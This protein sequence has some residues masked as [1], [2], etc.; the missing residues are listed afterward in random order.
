M[1]NNN[2]SRS[3]WSSVS[4]VNDVALMGL[5]EHGATGAYIH[6]AVEICLKTR[7]RL[8]HYWILNLDP[9]LITVH[10]DGTA[11]EKEIPHDE[12]ESVCQ[13]ISGRDAGISN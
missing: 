9:A 2:G 10:L 13:T 11:E 6:V 4:A 12:Y 8:S 5:S 3:V 1:D 7:H